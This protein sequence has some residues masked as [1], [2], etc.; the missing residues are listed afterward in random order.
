MTKRP[1]THAVSIKMPVILYRVI[2]KAARENGRKTGPQIVYDLMQHYVR[3]AV[4]Q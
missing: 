2:A 3:K 4:G 1:K